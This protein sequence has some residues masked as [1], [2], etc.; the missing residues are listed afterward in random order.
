VVTTITSCHRSPDCLE[1]TNRDKNTCAEI[2]GACDSLLSEITNG[3]TNKWII[4]GDDKL[5]PPVLRDLNST[6]VTVFSGLR[7]GTNYASGVTISV[8][9]TRMGLGIS[10]QQNDYGNGH[11][12]WELSADSDGE[13]DVPYSVD[14]PTHPRR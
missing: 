2:A 11:A 6:E 8:G 4:K 9:K 3:T 1:F 14:N 13:H 5:L 7:M 10:W 12:P